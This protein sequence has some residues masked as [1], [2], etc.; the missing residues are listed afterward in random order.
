MQAAHN[1][2]KNK[3]KPVIFN[4][5][6][7][8]IRLGIQGSLR[9]KSDIVFFH[10]YSHWLPF[11]NCMVTIYISIRDTACINY[12]TYF[13]EYKSKKNKSRQKQVAFINI[14]WK[15]QNEGKVKIL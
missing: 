11:M 15:S 10:F 14:K 9:F 1:I 12:A 3:N 13:S 6:L 5:E 2:A 8:F 7:F 4:K